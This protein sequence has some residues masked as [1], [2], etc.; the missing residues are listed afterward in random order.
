MVLGRIFGCADAAFCK[1]GGQQVADVVRV[2]AVQ[3]SEVSQGLSVV[4]GCDPVRGPGGDPFGGVSTAAITAD[5]P[6]LAA[7]ARS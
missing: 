4:A 5:A 7:T 1:G 2:V 3:P 6:S